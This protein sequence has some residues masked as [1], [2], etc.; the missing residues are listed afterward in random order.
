MDSLVKE[1]AEKWLA[2]LLLR[3]CLLVS[4][5]GLPILSQL[6]YYGL[7]IGVLGCGGIQS[8]ISSAT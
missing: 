2:L 6:S 4:I 8:L 7:S 5:R 3:L 1:S